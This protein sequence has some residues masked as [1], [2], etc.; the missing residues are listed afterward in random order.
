MTARLICDGQY[1]GT[2]TTNQVLLL[3]T[4][5]PHKLVSPQVILLIFL[6]G[7]FQTDLSITNA[8][9]ASLSVPVPLDLHQ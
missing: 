8:N 2:S 5:P 9:M 4:L 3:S 6:Q 7:V 1:G